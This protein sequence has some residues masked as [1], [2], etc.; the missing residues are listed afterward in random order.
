MADVAA[1]WTS[2]N[3]MHGVTG[4]LSTTGNRVSII[5]NPKKDLSKRY[6]Y[7]DLFAIF[8]TD[9]YYQ[10]FTDSAIVDTT[11]KGVGITEAK[12]PNIHGVNI[13]EYQDFPTSENLIGVMG[14]KESM[15]FAARTPS[16]A[17]WSDL[18]QVGRISKVTEPR[19]GLTVQVREHY[20]MTLG[21]RQ[22]TFTLIYGV[23]KGNPRC[24]ERLQTP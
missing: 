6:V 5:L 1:T 11:F 17:G 7:G 16:D 23:A 12:L 9:L 22:V 20:N 13:S 8:N 21:R 10:L 14:T 2:G 24:L 4:S 3:F 15:I 18:P 19:S